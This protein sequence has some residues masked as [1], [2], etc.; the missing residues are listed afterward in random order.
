MFAL[1]ADSGAGISAEF[2]QFGIG[3][4]ERCVDGDDQFVQ[5]ADNL[6][7]FLAVKRSRLVPGNSFPELCREFLHFSPLELRGYLE[8][9]KVI[10]CTVECLFGRKG[11]VFAEE[12]RCS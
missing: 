2:A 10:C 6:G 3:D 7:G 9:V 11:E 4:P 8:P 1:N 5:D 12:R